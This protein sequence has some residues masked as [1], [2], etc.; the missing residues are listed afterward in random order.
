MTNYLWLATAEGGQWHDSDAPVAGADD[1]GL[2]YGDGVFETV[3][4]RQGL[5]V[6]LD[7]HVQ[8]LRAGLGQLKIA[9]PKIWGD[10][11]PL[12]CQQVIQKNSVAEGVLKI[13]VSRGAGRR[14]FAPPP[15][16]RPRLVVQVTTRS[17]VSAK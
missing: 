16:T 9:Q 15:E 13:T 14:G 3:K 5:P 6:F 2:A 10:D 7:R 1:R 11:L 17:T 12:W 8:R 4:V